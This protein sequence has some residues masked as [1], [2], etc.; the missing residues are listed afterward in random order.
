MSTPKPI[1]DTNDLRM[2]RL[3]T[4]LVT[5]ALVLIEAG[6]TAALIMR[7]LDSGV[8]GTITGVIVGALAGFGKDTI[9]GIF[10]NG[11]KKKGEQA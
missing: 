2:N 11:K 6:L 10:N 8:Y 7:R 4:P 1:V 5:I 9:A 3:N